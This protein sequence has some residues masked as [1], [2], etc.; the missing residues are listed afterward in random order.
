MDSNQRRLSSAV[1]LTVSLLLMSYMV[2]V[3]RFELSNRSL[4]RGAF[5]NYAT[6]ASLER[7]CGG[8]NG[9]RQVKEFIGAAGQSRTAY[10]RLFRP[11]LYQ[12]SYHGIWLLYLPTAVLLS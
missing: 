9:Y 10:A 8:I 11:T 4:I 1:L 5:T 6:P 2:Q 7:G 12:L 3:A